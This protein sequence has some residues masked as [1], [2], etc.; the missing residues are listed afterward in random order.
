MAFQTENL[1]MFAFQ[2]KARQL[3]IERRAM[4]CFRRMTKLAA[5]RLEPMI[6]LAVMDV[7]MT[8]LAGCLRKCKIRFTG[9]ARFRRFV[10]QI[11]WHGQVTAG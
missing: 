11:A 8:G 6:E 1:A 10:A 4:P 3:M 9:A 2:R 5:P 7:F